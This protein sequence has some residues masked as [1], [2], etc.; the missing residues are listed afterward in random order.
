M[1]EEPLH[2]AEGRSRLVSGHHVASTLRKGDKAEVASPR[3]W[4]RRLVL[5]GPGPCPSPCYVTLTVRKARLVNSF[6]KPPICC[7]PSSSVKIQGL[8]ATSTCQREGPG[9]CEGLRIPGPRGKAQKRGQ[10]APTQP[11]GVVSQ[12]QLG[13]NPQAPSPSTRIPNPQ[14]EAPG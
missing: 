4:L 8:R 9:G 2:H 3:P 14:G 1:S 11:D 6:T 5:G 13:R 10:A 7:W 12:L